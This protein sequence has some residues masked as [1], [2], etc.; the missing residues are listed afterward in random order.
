MNLIGLFLLSGCAE[1]DVCIS[2]SL[3]KGE[4]FVLISVIFWVVSI[5]V[6]D[7][8]VKQCDVVDL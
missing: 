3:G 1:S 5:M 2:G 4:Q 6:A 7:A 8:A